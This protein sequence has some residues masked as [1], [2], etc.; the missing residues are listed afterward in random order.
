MNIDELIYERQLARQ[1]KDF[2]KS[3]SIRSILDEELVFVFDGKGTE[4]EVY[5]LTK[6]YFAKKP[7]GMDNRKYVEKRIQDDIRAEKQLNAW[8]YTMSK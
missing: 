5:Y 6:K 1:A 2:K 4:Q 7:T 3:D 8:I